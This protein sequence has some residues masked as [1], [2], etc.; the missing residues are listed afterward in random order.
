[1][2]A[3]L[4]RL[5]HDREERQ[6]DHR[7]RVDGARALSLLRI[8]AH[9]TEAARCHYY[10]STSSA[11]TG[12]SP[13]A[14]AES[15]PSCPEPVFAQAE[16]RPTRTKVRSLSI[17]ILARRRGAA[18]GGAR[19]WRSGPALP[20]LPL[21]RYDGFHEFD[22]IDSKG[23]C[24]SGGSSVARG[25][26]CALSLGTSKADRVERGLTDN[27]AGSDGHAQARESRG[28]RGDSRI[29]RQLCT[30]PDSVVALRA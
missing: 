17:N 29:A 26:R 11:Q 7:F 27:H 21:L 6:P 16:Q 1:M 13:G 18:A 2:H 15:P 28:D 4:W 5:R 24:R 3:A 23:R 9:R 12:P 14:S 25:D 22:L 8:R 30:E 10:A 20:P 19:P